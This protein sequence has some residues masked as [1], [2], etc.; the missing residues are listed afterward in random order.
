MSKTAMSSAVE[1]PMMLRLYV[2]GQSP[3]SVLAVAKVR[4]QLAR[5]PGAQ[6]EVVDVLAT[7][8]RAAAAGILVTPTLE[9][10]SG[11]PPTRIIGSLIN[12]EDVFVALG[13]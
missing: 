5:H 12:V 10:A 11:D 4:A 13:V 9:L 2:A 1:A 8:A 3:N 7:P 6:L